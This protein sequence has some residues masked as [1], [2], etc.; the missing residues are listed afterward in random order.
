MKVM[1]KN[2]RLAFPV[3]NKPEQFQGEGKPRYSATLLFP[4]DDENHKAVKAAM[5]E[6]AVAKWGEAKADAAVKGLTAALKTALGDGDLKAEYTGFEGNMY[7]GAH[8]QASAPPRLL[9][10]RKQELPRDTGVIYPGCYV[11]A[12]VEFWGQDNQWGKRINASLRGIQF[13]KDGDSFAAGAPA[14]LDEFE[15]VDGAPIDE[16]TE[17]DFA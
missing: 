12:S 4:K 8:S 14:S 13:V 15:T 5:R 2:V 16:A 1:L 10:G 17:S 6:A 7:V 9:D 3:L 11:N